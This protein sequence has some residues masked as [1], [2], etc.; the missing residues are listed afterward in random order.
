MTIIVTLTKEDIKCNPIG[1]HLMITTT[2]GIQ[3]NLNT[4]AVEELLNDL[5]DFKK[6]QE[7][8]K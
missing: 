3:I 8:K 1:T 4:E 5:T 2:G 7:Q 6:L